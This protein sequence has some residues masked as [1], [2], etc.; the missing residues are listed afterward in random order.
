MCRRWI[1][2]GLKILNHLAFIW[3]KLLMVL[4]FWSL[5]RVDHGLKPI[6]VGFVLLNATRTSF[7]FKLSLTQDK[8]KKPSSFFNS[9]YCLFHYGGS[10][11][12]H[13]CR[14]PP[15]HGTPG[16]SNN[17]FPS[18]RRTRVF[19]LTVTAC[20]AIEREKT[21]VK[22]GYSDWSKAEVSTSIP[23]TRSG[24]VLAPKRLRMLCFLSVVSE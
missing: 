22:G 6:L 11:L 7:F 9:H 2:G 13:R 17:V 5:Q 24:F 19:G 14:D 16:S 12:H 18:T 21:K 10:G 3:V 1:Q 23:L 4:P 8:E 20:Y 15:C